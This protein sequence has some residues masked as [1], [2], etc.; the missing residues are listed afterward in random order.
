MQIEPLLRVEDIMK[1]FGTSRVTIYRWV[2]EA[3]AGKSR[4]PAPLNGTKRKLL[5]SADRIAR[6]CETEPA[7]NGQTGN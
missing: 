1:I 6:F 2:N 4:F 7:S 5:W 3:R